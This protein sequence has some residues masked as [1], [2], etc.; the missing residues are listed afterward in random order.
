LAFVR[1]SHTVLFFINKEAKIY[2][3]QLLYDCY[4]FL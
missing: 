3:F 1:L 4:Q 2:C